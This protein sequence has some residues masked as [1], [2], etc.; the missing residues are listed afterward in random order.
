MQGLKELEEYQQKE[1]AIQRM[2]TN[3]FLK[4]LNRSSV[5]ALNSGN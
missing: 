4:Y 1:S 3:N 2:D 5:P